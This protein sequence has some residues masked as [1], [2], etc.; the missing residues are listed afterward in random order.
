MRILLDECLPGRLKRG[1]PGH[2]VLT[3]PK[4]GWAG[5]KNGV[6]LRLAAEHFDVFLT[7]DRG[8][9]FQQNVVGIDIAI[10]VLI[11]SANRLDALRPLMPAVLDRLASLQ[12]GTV[13]HI[14]R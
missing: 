1:L 3:I 8:L 12:R 10:V 6:L 2:E 14:Y 11:A 9:P 7:V 13:T 4:A 5:R